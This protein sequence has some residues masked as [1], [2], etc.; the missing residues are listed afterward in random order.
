MF[1]SLQP[2]GLQHAKLP[3]PSPTL[4]ACS[5]SCP[6]NWW[7]HP[8]IS[9]SV[10]PFSSCLQSYPASGSFQMSQFFT[11]GDQVLELQHQSSNEHSG[12]IS[13]R[14][15]WFDLLVVQ[16]TLKCLLQHHSSKA[17]I[18]VSW[19]MPVLLW[20]FPL[21]LLLQCPAGVQ[22]QLIQG[23][24]RRDCLGDYLYANQRCQE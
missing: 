21:G 3:C 11:S 22:P 20:T 7:Y 13:F 4:R 17:S 8:I 12:L 10:V 24:R 23:I 14:M 6:S 16:G 5:V 15:D 9:S 19:G 1:D 2:H 18:L